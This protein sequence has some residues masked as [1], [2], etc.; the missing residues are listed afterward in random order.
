MLAQTE[1]SVCPFT[2]EIT[3]TA[4]KQIAHLPQETYRV[5]RERLRAVAELAPVSWHPLAARP[6]QLETSLSFRVG[7]F[8]ALY[9]ADPHARRIR[10]LE[11]ARR[12]PTD[13]S[14]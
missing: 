4:W 6:L 8:A 11:V 9:E 1:S 3:P 14:H 7:E 5:L 2:V 10:L 12:L 13:V